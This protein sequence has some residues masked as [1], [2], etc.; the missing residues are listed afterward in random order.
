MLFADDVVLLAPSDHQY[1]LGWFAAKCE[2]AGMRIKTS[3]SETVVLDQEKVAF[4]LKVTGEPQ[5]QMFRYFGSL[6]HE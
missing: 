3:R 6:V 1:L 4:P 5:V 2:T